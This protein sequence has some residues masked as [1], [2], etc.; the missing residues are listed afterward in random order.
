MRSAFFS[1]R[2]RFLISLMA[3]LVAAMLALVFIGSLIVYPGMIRDEREQSINELDRLEHTIEREMQTLLLSAK[4]WATWDDTY[5]FIQGSDDNYAAS[6]F[7]RNM[8]EDLDYQFMLFFDRQADLH[9]IAGIDPASDRYDS[10]PGQSDDCA[11][12]KSYAD[13]LRPLLGSANQP[14]STHLERQGDRLYYAAIHPIFRTDES[15]PM[16]GWLVQI[17]FLDDQWEARMAAQTGREGDVL[18]LPPAEVPPE[19]QI[20]PTGDGRIHVAKTL[21]LN[22]R[23]APTLLSTYLPRDAFL[24]RMATVRYAQWWTAGLLL[25]VIVLVLLLLELV[26]LHPLRQLATF[27][28]QAKQ[29]ATQA[30]L[31]ERLLHRQDEIG[32]LSREFLHLIQHQRHRTSQLL[33]LSQTDHLTGLANRRLFDERLNDLM[34]ASQPPVPV[35]GILLDIDYFKNYNDFYGHPA[36]DRCLTRLAKCLQQ[37]VQQLAIDRSLLAR[38]GGEEFAVIL[39]GTSPSRV[40]QLAD[41]LCSAVAQMKLPNDKSRL[42]IVTVSVG[43]AICA[44]DEL[45]PPTL[46]ARCDAALY[47][48]KQRGRNRIEC[49]LGKASRSHAEERL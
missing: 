6:N 2:G 45:S 25:T 42:G 21:S 7:S 24:E 11:W 30:E 49:D 10:C 20:T 17:Q 40:A 44:I 13:K 8:F 15:G 26:V 1:L 27:T 18:P 5:A 22:P 38:I 12:A 16:Q 39:P 3:L 47:R 34:D 29:D 33:N 41:A 14:A 4:D 46:L 31:P 23:D 19:L 48:A 35:A 36:G 43:V 28:Q 37:T 32:A 9:W